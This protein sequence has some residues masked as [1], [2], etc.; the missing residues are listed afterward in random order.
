MLDGAS[1]WNLT[2][3]GMTRDVHHMMAG[4]LLTLFDLS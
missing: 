1:E 2:R 4:V 3:S